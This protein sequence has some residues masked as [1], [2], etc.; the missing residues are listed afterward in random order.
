MSYSRLTS[1][2]GVSGMVGTTQGACDVMYIDQCAQ[3]FESI[4]VNIRNLQ[5]L[6]LDTY[7]A[8][9]KYVYPLSERLHH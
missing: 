7:T 5:S 3:A 1:I 6:T 8:L 9:C 2:A 4:L